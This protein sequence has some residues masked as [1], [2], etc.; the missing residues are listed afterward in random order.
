MEDLQ[1]PPSPNHS[2]LSDPTPLVIPTEAYP[3]FLL[4]D[5]SNGHVCGSPQR[6]PHGVHQ[7]HGSRQEIRGSVVEGSAVRPSAL[8][9]PSW[10]T[11]PA[12]ST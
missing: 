4:R 10:E 5:A 7:R 12:N 3:D 2:N 11:D 1:F 8:S 6:E 9:N